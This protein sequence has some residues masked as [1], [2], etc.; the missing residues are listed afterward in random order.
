MNTILK[1]SLA[2]ALLG[3]TA[4]ASAAEYAN[5]VSATPVTASVS[6]PRQDCYQGEQVVQQQPSGAGALIGAIAGGVIGNQFGHGFGRAAATGL[7]V[8]AGSAIGNNVEANANSPQAVA[9]RRCRTVDGYESRV[10][11]YDVVYEYN[12][13]RY[14]TR[15]PNDPGPRLA[16]DIRPANN[17]PLD[18]VGPPQGHGAVPPAYAQAAPS[19]S[20]PSYGEVPPAAYHDAGPAYYDARPAY[21][22]PAPVYY[23][24][25]YPASYYVAPAAIGIGLGYWAGRTWYRGHR[26]GWHGHRGRH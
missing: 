10:V 1:T 23:S 25:P 14:T 19:Y 12:G 22:S 20:A 21:Y 16:I 17:A 8:V 9:V 6:A 3:A 26:G 15:L 24:S 13:Q 7:G 11:G 18:R 2:A 4:T 5:V